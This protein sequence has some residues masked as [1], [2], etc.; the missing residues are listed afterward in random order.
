MKYIIKI[1]RESENKDSKEDFM[2]GLSRSYDQTLFS[3]SMDSDETIEILQHLDEL[4]FRNL[5]ISTK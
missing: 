4:R 5:P 2:R 3:S 1:I